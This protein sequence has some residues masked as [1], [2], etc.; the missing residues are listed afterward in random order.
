MP[1]ATDGRLPS[2]TP[3]DL[4]ERERRQ[5]R[6]GVLKVFLGAAPGVGKTYRM[7]D[8]GHRRA[9]RGTDVVV[10]LVECHRRRHTLALV[11]GLEVVPRLEREYRGTVVSEMDLEA[12]LARRPEVALVDEL[13]HSNPPGMRNAKRW[14]DVETLLAAGID[15]VTTVNIQH[16]E[17]VNDVVE[18]IT[19]VPQRETVPDEMVRRADQ[20]ELVDMPAEALRRRMAHGNV[21]SAEKVDAALANYFRIGNLTALRELALLWVAGR[22][23]EALHRY[24]SE[25]GIGRVWETKERVVVALTGGPEGETLIR[26]AARIADRSAG[27]GSPG[28]DGGRDLLA[29]HVARSDGLAVGAS[30]AALARQRQLVESLGGS[31]HSVVGD[32]VSGALLEFARGVGAT[33]LVLGTSS[34]RRWERL[35]TGRGIGE[36]TV[37]SSAD[38]DVHMV[39]HERA[40]HGRL[41]PSR[42]RT[43]TTWR[44]VAGPVSGL[45]LPVA[46]TAV[47]ANSRGSLN[48]TSE[49]LLFLLAVVGVAC[50]GGV[51][52]A[53]VASVTAS[54]LLNYYF[55]PPVGKFTIAEPNNILALAVFVV[56]AGTV[57]AVVDRSLRL[58]RRAARATAEAET[59]SS[60]AGSI[61]RGGDA[62]PALLDR[63]R[64]TFGMDSAELVAAD[65]GPPEPGAASDAGPE[66]PEGP[67]G[68]SEVRVPAGDGMVLVL[69]GRSLSASDQRVLAAFA[70]HVSGAAERARLAEVAAEV[71]PV[72]AADRMRT[73]LLAAVSHDLRTP[74]AVGWAAVS[75]L[76]SQDVEFSAEDR[77]ELL[78]TAEESLARLSRL[79]DNLLDMSRLQAGALRLR[80]RATALEEVLPAALE[81]LPADAPGIDT[82]GLERAPAVLADPPLLERIIA[83]LLANAVRHAPAQHPVVLTASALGDRVE[84]RVVDRGPGLPERDR[85]RAFEPFQRMGDHD[86]GTGLGLG[87]ALARGL[88]EAMHGSLTPEDTPGGGLTMVLSLPSAGPEPGPVPEPDPSRSELYQ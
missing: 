69:R 32:D 20:I 40:G 48:L 68:T 16:L 47:L 44:L 8:E 54:L 78:A 13:P 12:V 17:S 15:V 51:V 9:E 42:R 34:R 55:I 26:R 65:P 86:N 74:L 14:Q 43:L 11:D 18:K 58:S 87:L 1:D 67:G 38:I 36:T 39:T 73:A 21:Y 31:Y 22:V 84:L 25:H 53:V 79:V 6:R 30:P 2:P 88:T 27:G 57:A 46:L 70:A 4:W 10:A 85:E 45:V 81:S 83:N 77:E 41:L 59:L 62:L 7:L 37:G 28:I 29:V 5:G 76:R 80:L 61:V 64:E 72:K 23:D 75:S 33:Q 63:A 3:S 56:V 71:E 49:A 52:S 66:G 19:E 24:R 35:L 50:F 60:L 82:H